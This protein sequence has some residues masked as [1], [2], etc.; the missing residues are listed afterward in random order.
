MLAEGEMGQGGAGAGCYHSETVRQQPKD[1]R[2]TREAEVGM[3]TAHRRHSPLRPGQ[4]EQSLKNTLGK[5]LL[6][7]Q[8][9]PD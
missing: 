9:E 2:T 5:G 7:L 8:Q 6:G 1:S 4:E 3:A